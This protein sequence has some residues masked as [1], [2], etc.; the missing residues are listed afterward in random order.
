MR[1]LG[2]E[3]SCDESAAAVVDERGR[4]LGE[5]LYSQHHEHERFK[6]VVP[7]VA[8]RSHVHRLPAMVQAALEQAG[9]AAC[10]GE[11][12]ACSGGGVD[13]VAVTLG[14]GL[15]GGLMVGASLAR[16]LAHGWGK[17]VL[18]INHLEGH[19]LSPRLVRKIPFPYLLLLAS[20]G[21]CQLVLVEGVGRYKLWGQTLDDAAGEVFDKGAVMLGLGYPGG[22]AVAA[23]A[24]LGSERGSGSVALPRPLAGQGFDFSF[25]GL[26][27]AL[28]LH[29]ARERITLPIEAGLR[30]NL[31]A[32]LEAAIVESLL[33][34]VGRGCARFVHEVGAG[35][36]LVM[37]GG[38]AC[39]R[40]LRSEMESLAEEHGMDLVVPA[41]RLCTDNAVMIAWAGL[42]RLEAGLACPDQAPRPRWGLESLQSEAEMMAR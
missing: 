7:E 3:S 36:A 22:P 34:K 18:G 32:S 42:E 26:K 17:P 30:A 29:L 10:P 1:V 11:S 4:V 41:P 5:A 12:R 2:I 27:S 20:G 37:A 6:G 13:A 40:R 16:A 24:A 38:V 8:A 39:N 35:G 9:L 15:M 28:R 33:D 14:P 31:A 19:A 23:E 21:H 25:S